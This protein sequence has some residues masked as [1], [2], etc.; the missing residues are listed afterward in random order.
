VVSKNTVIIVYPHGPSDDKLTHI[1]AQLE[2]NPSCPTSIK[3]GGHQN[4]ALLW[5]E[6]DPHSST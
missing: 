5:Q 4:M 6:F 1:L 2:I 3:Q